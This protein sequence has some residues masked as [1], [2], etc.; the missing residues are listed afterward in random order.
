MKI[1]KKKALP[2]NFKELIEAGDI[3]ALKA[4]FDVCELDARGGYLKSTALSF[5]K[6]PDELTRW[7]VEQGAD[8][9]AVN[10]Y[11]ETALHEQAASWCGNVELLLEL[12]AAIEAPDYQNETP[13]HH[14]A[15][16][17]QLKAVRALAAHGANVNAGD[18][19]GRT[20]LAKA[21]AHCQNTNIA[22]MAEIAAFL[23]DA[24][25]TITP[26]M[27]ADVKRI[28]EQFEFHRA[29][30]NQDELTETDAGLARLYAL[31]HVASVPKRQMHDGVSPITVNTTK[32]QDQHAELWDL[33]VPSQGAAQTV[34][35][36]AIRVSGRISHEILDNGG[37]NWDADFRKMLNALLRHLGSGTALDEV[38]LREAAELGARIRD[39]D[40]DDEELSRL[41]ELA[42]RWVLAN[43]KPMPVGSIDYRR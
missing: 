13:L 12:G 4:V 28:G 35:G 17:Y 11:Q 9:N 3:S 10:Q 27:L 6:I 38:Q 7:L 36:E 29:N 43:P 41:S 23:L 21:L 34:Q 14:A 22:H 19:T 15:G 24:G 5:F 18:D 42:V 1:K 37:A 25:A 31:F 32:W 33:L 20:P 39:G 8:V 30:F 40:G 26:E 16:S 2:K